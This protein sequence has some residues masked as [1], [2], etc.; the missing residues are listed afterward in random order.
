[1]E[2]FLNDL[3]NEDSVRAAIK[4]N[5]LSYHYHLWNA[6]NAELAV[7]PYLTWFVTDMPDHF[8]NVVVC[9]PVPGDVIETRL[10]RQ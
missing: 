5:W 2:S 6:A 9:A 4:E 7:G 8:M 1:M 3:S 10:Y